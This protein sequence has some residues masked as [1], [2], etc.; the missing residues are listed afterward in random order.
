MDGRIEPPPRRGVEWRGAAESAAVVVA[1][2]V[3]VVAGLAALGLGL[4]GMLTGTSLGPWGTAIGCGL[5]LLGL[6]WSLLSVGAVAAL[7][8]L[9]LVVG[10]AA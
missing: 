8:A 5:L 6:P 4:V 10:A 1:R 7:A 9:L 3:C 2:I